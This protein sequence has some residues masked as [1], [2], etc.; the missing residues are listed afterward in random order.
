MRYEYEC[1]TCKGRLVLR[2]AIAMRDNTVVCDGYETLAHPHEPI[3][4]K[5]VLQPTPHIMR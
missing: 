4:M 3:L 5:R 1:P 2:R